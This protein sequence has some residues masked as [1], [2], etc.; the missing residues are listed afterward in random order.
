L[1]NGY[2]VVEAKDGA[3]AH[4][5]FS[6]N[7]GDFNIIFSDV[8]LPDKLG[9]DLIEEI[10]KLKPD[11]GIVLTSGYSDEKSRIEHIQEK[12]YKF[13][14]KPY[15]I[16]LLL[17]TIKETLLQVEMDDMS[18]SNQDESDEISDPDL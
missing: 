14:Q 15:S 2:Q 8:V 6:E 16:K 17:S 3:E 11:I 4:S 9:T 1:E 7:D 5:A 13:L 10:K 18:L 12:G